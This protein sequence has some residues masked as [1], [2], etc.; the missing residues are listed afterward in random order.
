MENEET[1]NNFTNQPLADESMSGLRCF[2]RD[3]SQHFRA[4]EV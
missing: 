1:L 3:P 2:L 4:K